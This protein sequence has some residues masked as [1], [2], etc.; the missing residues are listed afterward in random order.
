MASVIVK[1]QRHMRDRL[2]PALSPYPMHRL[3]IDQYHEMIDSG[4]LT[5]DDRI[6]PTG[7]E[8]PQTKIIGLTG[9]HVVSTNRGSIP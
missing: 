4:V 2:R 7:Q 9:N 5:E 3:T 6:A 8:A 1:P